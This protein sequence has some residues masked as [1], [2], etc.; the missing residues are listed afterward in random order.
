[1]FVHSLA[2]QVLEIGVSQGIACRHTL[3]NDLLGFSLCLSPCELAKVKV[4]CGDL[5]QGGSGYPRSFGRTANVLGLRPRY[6][7]THTDHLEGFVW[8][9]RGV[10][11]RSSC[12]EA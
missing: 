1:M 10:I 12:G 3:L 4:G 8:G 9:A 5:R 7:S 6:F 2:A 11:A